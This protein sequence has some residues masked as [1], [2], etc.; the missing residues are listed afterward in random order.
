MKTYLVRYADVKK[1]YAKVQAADLVIGE[2]S[3]TAM[4][5]DESGKIRAIFPLDQIAAVVE[6]DEKE[7]AKYLAVAA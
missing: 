4:L 2:N 7:V 3:K 1:G 5:R 6:V